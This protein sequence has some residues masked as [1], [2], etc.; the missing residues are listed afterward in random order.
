MATQQQTTTSA[1]I[2]DTSDRTQYY[3]I[4]SKIGTNLLLTADGSD[5]VVSTTATNPIS[6]RQL[7]AK[8]PLP[9]N[10]F[11]LV[12]KAGGKKLQM[13]L[14]TGKQAYVTNV[15]GSV[16]VFP[17]HGFGEVNIEDIKTQ[18]VMDINSANTNPGTPVI[19]W[20]NNNTPC[21]VWIFKEHNVLQ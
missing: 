7:W 13:D 6:E 20:T 9:G 3:Y 14:K 18:F 2:T 11:Y 5:H 21:Q 19:S 16:V 1:N 17:N 10:A 8:V 15:G 4:L 12:L